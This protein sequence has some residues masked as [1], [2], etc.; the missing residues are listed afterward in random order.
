MTILGNCQK[1]IDTFGEFEETTL[2]TGINNLIEFYTR[3]NE[4]I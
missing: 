3:K 1:F 2:Q 4:S